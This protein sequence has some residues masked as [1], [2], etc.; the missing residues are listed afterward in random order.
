MLRHARSLKDVRFDQLRQIV[1][2]ID[3]LVLEQ[4]VAAGLIPR[5][6]LPHDFKVIANRLCRACLDCD[7]SV[8]VKQPW[9]ENSGTYQLQFYA[10]DTDPALNYRQRIRAD[11]GGL[12]RSR[13]DWLQYI[14]QCYRVA[15]DR[16]DLSQC[17][18]ELWQVAVS[19]DQLTDRGG[20]PA[21]MFCQVRGSNGRLGQLGQL[22]GVLQ[23]RTFTQR[24]A[25][26]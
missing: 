22:Q 13:R 8:M 20:Q 14:R 19:E 10:V 12:P 21:Q 18:T 15:R 2:V 5:R 24:G 4:V 23:W 6:D 7:V 11:V 1:P 9:P 3:A 16:E 25:Q 26:I 17:F